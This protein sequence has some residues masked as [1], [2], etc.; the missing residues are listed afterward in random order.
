VGS[1]PLLVLLAALL[2]LAAGCGGGG[3]SQGEV[4]EAAARQAQ[5]RARRALAARVPRGASSALRALYASFPPP[6]PDPA[7]EGSGAAI[8]A[9]EGA[10]AQRTPLQV[11][12]RFYAEARNDLNPNQRKLI[13]RLSHYEAISRHDP[14]FS[15]GQLAAD[16]YAATLPKAI[17]RYGYQG[18]VYALARQLEREM[19]GG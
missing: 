15:A 17:A 16:A 5:A 3:A 7:R 9:G 4:Q 18:C 1:K 14:S 13:A 19:E 10:C 8:R 6:K 2:L 12:A 11:K